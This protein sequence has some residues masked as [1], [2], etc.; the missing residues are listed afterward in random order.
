MR[1]FATPAKKLVNIIPTTRTAAE[2]SIFGAHL[3]RLC[4]H[5]ALRA[6]CSAARR[7]SVRARA[8]GSVPPTIGLTNEIFK[9]EGCA[10]FD[11]ENGLDRAR[12]LVDAIDALGGDVGAA[13]HGV[14]QHGRCL[15][16]QALVGDAL[17]R[18][19]LCGSVRQQ[20]MRALCPSGHEAANPIC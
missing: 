18:W 17:V 4:S 2:V 1:S 16:K 14:I 12:S 13:L 8:R 11:N 9:N 19:L 6:V 7:R 10:A 15:R 3:P 5:A 20:R